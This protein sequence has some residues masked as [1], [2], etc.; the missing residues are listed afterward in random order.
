MIIWHFSSFVY[1][2]LV[3]QFLE[4]LPQFYQILPSSK[5]SRYSIIPQH[6]NFRESPDYVQPYDRADHEKPL[7]SSAFNPKISVAPPHITLTFRRILNI[8]LL[9]F[10]L[11]RDYFLNLQLHFSIE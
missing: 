5:Q 3:I 9:S 2:S 4:K 6:L 8:F 7:F 10:L 1:H 11:R